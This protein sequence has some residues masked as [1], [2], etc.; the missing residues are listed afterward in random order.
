MT[1]TAIGG[2]SPVAAH[3]RI[4]RFPLLFLL[5]MI[6]IPGI[7]FNRIAFPLQLVASDSLGATLLSMSG[8]SVFREGNLINLAHLSLEVAGGVQWYSV[9]DFT[10]HV[11]FVVWLFLRRKPGH[12]A[13]ASRGNHPRR[14][15]GERPASGGHRNRSHLYGAEAAEGFFHSFSGWVVFGVARWRSSLRGESPRRRCGCR[16]LAST[17]GSSGITT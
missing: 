11:K 16:P 13:V 4:P 2:T 6:P 5:F 17:L 7:I 14:H 10:V 12:P 8:I 9:I 3:V 1:A 15:P